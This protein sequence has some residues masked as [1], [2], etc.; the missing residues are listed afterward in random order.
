MPVSDTF[1]LIISERALLE[2]TYISMSLKVICEG[3]K[4]PSRGR[5]WEGGVPP[6]RA[7]KFLHLE[8]EKTVSD[9]CFWGKDHNYTRI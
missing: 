5:V 9:A 7:G 1:I 8:P 2:I 6:P 3:A 4:R